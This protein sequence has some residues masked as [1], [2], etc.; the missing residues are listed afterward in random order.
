MSRQPKIR[1]RKRDEELLKKTLRN[2]NA[3]LR[4]IEKKNPEN[5]KYLPKFSKKIYDEF[6]ERDV[7]VF[8]DRLSLE[9]AKDL[10]STREDFNR[11]IDALKRF[12][13]RGAEDLVQ[14]KSFINSDGETINLDNNIFIT[15]WQKHQMENLLP[16][17]NKNREI[18]EKEIAET[19]QKRKGESKGYN[20]AQIGMGSQ[21][22]R[23]L[24][25]IN[26]YFR[27]MDLEDLMWKFR[28]ILNESTSDYFE[29]RDELL[30]G[31]YIKSLVE[32]FNPKDIEEITNRIKRMSAKEFLRIFYEQGG[33]FEFSYPPDEDQ[34]QGYLEEISE[35]WLPNEMNDVEVEN[36]E[37]KIVGKRNEWK[38]FNNKNELIGKFD[39]K[40]EMNQ[41][42]KNHEYKILKD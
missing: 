17:I 9:Q 42:I 16:V 30:R 37:V 24:K 40:K 38:L 13:R 14:V 19:E 29:N 12:S 15:K 11:R 20:Y 7:I 33:N 5:A 10:I 2:F 23:E 26:P 18:R 31:N 32:N 35:I 34:Y 41:Y 1:W 36:N 6:D 22:K 4:R 21:T 8:T 39:N 27:T 25:P 3:K 28:T